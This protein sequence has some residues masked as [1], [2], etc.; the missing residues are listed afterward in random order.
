MHRTSR[1]LV[2]LKIRGRRVNLL[3]FARGRIIRLLLHKDFKDKAAT[4][5]AKAR[6]IISRWQIF[7]GLQPA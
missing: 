5:K 3:L 1:M 6:S 4:T 2:L 7:Q